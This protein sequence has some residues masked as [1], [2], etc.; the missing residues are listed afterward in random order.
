MRVLVVE[1][2]EFLAEMIAEGLRRDAVAVDIAPDG[3]SALEKLRFGA[4]DVMI[5]DRDLPGLHGDEVCRRVVGARLLTRIL[6]LTAAGTVRD[7][8]AGLGLGADDYLTKPFAYD[9][10]L[11]R[12]LALGRRSRPALPPVLERAGL[13][14]DT[15]RR[16]VCRDGRYLSLSRKEFAVLETL[17]RAEGAVVSGDDLI[18]EVWEEDTSYRTNAVRV[19]LS[20][21]RTK[22]GAPPVIET[23]PGAGYRIG[24]GPAASGGSGGAR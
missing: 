12:V 19:T 23:V 18:E 24:D 21:L 14:L 1:D 6:M 7:R 8:V 9:E 17:L 5:L 16:Q 11:A 3:P 10:L 20:K 4:Y 15:A 22:L 2:E 13:T